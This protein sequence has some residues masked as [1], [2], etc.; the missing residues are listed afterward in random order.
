[1]FTVGAIG[2]ADGPCSKN[3][4]H[5]VCR[6]MREEAEQPCLRCGKPLGYETDFVGEYDGFSN[7]TGSTHFTCIVNPPRHIR[8]RYRLTRA[9]YTHDKRST[10]GMNQTSP[11]QDDLFQKKG[12]N[13]NNGKAANKKRSAPRF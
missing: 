7:T 13:K 8:E 2:T 3:C 1:M 6:L 10:Q 5:D 9:T 12:N 4:T 11:D